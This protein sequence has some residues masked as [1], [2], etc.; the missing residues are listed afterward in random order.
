MMRMRELGMI[1]LDLDW[2]EGVDWIG[3]GLKGM[4]VEVERKGKGKGRGGE[5][6]GEGKGRVWIAYCTVY[7][8]GE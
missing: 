2:I 7:K 5:G 6:E 4:E 3:I 1:E 8:G